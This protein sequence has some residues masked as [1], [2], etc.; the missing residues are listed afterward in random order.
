MTQINDLDLAKRTLLAGDY[1]LVIAKGGKLLFT[2]RETSIRPIY[3]A[4]QELGESLEGAS[5][6]DKVIGKAAALFCILGRVKSVYA[7]LI[8]EIAIETLQAAGIELEFEESCPY[9]LN[10]SRDGMC[11]IETLALDVDDGN[12]LLEKVGRFLGEIG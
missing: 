1:A 11:P 10:R 7:A 2:S 6:A 8:S 12:V 9:I 4:V 3:Q 5:I